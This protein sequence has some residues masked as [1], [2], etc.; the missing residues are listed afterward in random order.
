MKLPRQIALGPALVVA[1]VLAFAGALLWARG[2]D[3]YVREWFSVRTPDGPRVRCLAVSPKPLKPRPVVVYLHGTGGRLVNDGRELRRLAELGLAAVSVEYDQADAD[4]C[5]AQLAAVLRALGGRRWADTNAVA[6][7]GYSLGASRWADFLERVDEPLPAAMVR[8]A[9]GPVP[10]NDLPSVRWSGLPVLLAQGTGD[11]IFPISQLARSVA[12]LEAQGAQVEVWR[13]PGA[14]H[15]LREVRGGVLRAVGEW[16]RVQFGLSRAR[17]EERSVNEWRAAAT[18]LGYWLAPAILWLA[19]VWGWNRRPS[20]VRGRRMRA[21]EVGGAAGL[22]LRDDSRRH[23]SRRSAVGVFGAWL[24]RGL[25]GLV[26]LG[27]VFILGL[28]LVLPRL[29]ATE[30]TRAMAG[31]FLVSRGAQ[32]DFEW[33]AGQPSCAGWSIGRL[34]GHAELAHYNRG[35]VN[36]TVDDA[37]HR[38]F[39][40]SPVLGIGDAAEAG[41]WRRPLWESL[42]P[43]IRRES[44]PAGAASEVLRHLRERVTVAPL[45]SAGSVLAD[46]RRQATDAAGWELLV[47]AALRAVGIPARLSRDNCAEFWN[48][49]A[50]QAPSGWSHG[51]AG[52]QRP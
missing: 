48:G 7:M 12:L 17:T 22:S 39:A 37:A 6:W 5:A 1:G 13:I 50:W 44:A 25:A 30:R 36:W 38:D 8:L 32:G 31:A 35:L 27:A 51:I 49:E 47:V 2:R 16:C 42:Y 10:T 20:V 18:P 26:A 21:D 46:W 29:A 14:E 9:G 43:R 52:T 45:A 15:S 28:H 3:S 4:R 41:D 23:E 19:G 24:L 40:L 11:E 34:R 33:L